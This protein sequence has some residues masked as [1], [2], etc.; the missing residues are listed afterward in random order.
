MADLTKFK[1]DR[2]EDIVYLFPIFKWFGEDFVATYA[3]PE[4]AG[5]LNQTLSAVM[6]YLTT[7]VD[8]LFKPYLLRGKYQVKY[9]KY[10]WSLNEQ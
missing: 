7:H 3:P 6:N 5:N 4:N 8:A 10:D 1:I 9:L 2:K